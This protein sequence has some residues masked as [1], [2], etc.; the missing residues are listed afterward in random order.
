MNYTRRRLGVLG[1]LTGLA[2]AAGSFPALAADVVLRFAH[3]AP[4]T[5]VKGRTANHFAELVAQYTNGSVEVQVFP[6]GQLVPTTDELRAV[7]RGQ[8]DIVAPYTSYFSAI[9]SAWDIF[10][11]P[12]LFQDPEHAVGV[13]AGD[14]G[15]SLLESLSERGLVGL[16]IW[17]DGPVY[18]FSRGEPI[19]APEHLEGR[20]VRVAPSAPLESM[21]EKGG[22]VPVSM[23]ATDVYLA[24][25]QNV[26]DAVVTTST[27]A[28]P[29]RWNEVL[30]TGTRMMWGVGGYGLVINPDSLGRLS[31]E[32]REGFMRAVAEAESWNHEHALQNINEAEAYLAE[33]GLEWHEPTAE[34]RQAWLDAAQEVWAEQGGEV[35]ELQSQVAN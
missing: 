35:K 20:R 18:I 21:L 27:Y 8:V 11:Q 15:R 2:I 32:Q 9:D 33:H 25:Q 1:A 14:V 31:D 26:A 4:E 13:F 28:G 34:E 29:A 10:Y 16:A 12:L 5:A 24:L 30:D 22:A 19:T 3:E 17:H 7:A 23:P 6:G